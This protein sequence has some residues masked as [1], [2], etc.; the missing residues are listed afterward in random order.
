M[1][2]TDPRLALVAG[3]ASGDLLADLGRE[4][5]SETVD[6]ISVTYAEGKSRQTQY[7]AV[8]GYLRSFLIGGGGGFI[9]MERA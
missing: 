2:T 4:T 9:P 3:E 7:A 8:S 5:L 1:D 6:V